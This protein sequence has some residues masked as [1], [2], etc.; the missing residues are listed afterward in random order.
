MSEQIDEVIQKAEFSRIIRVDHLSDL[1]GE[2]GDPFSFA[3][4]EDERRAL[5][6]RFA[7]L[8]LDS[9]EADVVAT[10]FESKGR[11]RKVVSGVRLRV[12]FAADVVQS[13]VVTLEPVVAHLEQGFE[14]DYLPEGAEQIK[15]GISDGDGFAG[16][17]TGDFTGDFTSEYV[18]GEV[19]IDI[20]EVDPPEILI[21]NEIDVGEVIAENLSL[22][23]DPYPRAPEAEVDADQIERQNEEIAADNPF[24]VL[25][26]LKSRK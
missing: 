7:L 9:L 26:K 8:S 14:V 20:D 22:A 21:G 11:N 24:A 16:E 10:R 12:K 18:A 6:A 3:A 15:A 2:Q 25:Q 17:F 13:C 19:V 4:D 1:G 5:A 23:L